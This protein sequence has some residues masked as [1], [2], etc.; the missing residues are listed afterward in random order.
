[1]ELRNRTF[2]TWMSSPALKIVRI[3]GSRFHIAIERIGSGIRNDYYNRAIY[4]LHLRQGTSPI[5]SRISP[6]V[7]PKLE[8]VD[9]GLSEWP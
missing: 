5:V 8:A 3:W 7:T 4:V 6:S 1:M 2:I 9:R